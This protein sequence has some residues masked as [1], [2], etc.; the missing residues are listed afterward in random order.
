MKRIQPGFYDDDRGGLH[1]DLTEVLEASGY[2]NTPENRAVL[3]KAL[4]EVYPAGKI[5]ETD[6]P[7]KTDE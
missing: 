5:T 6:E 1:I 3:I 7:I 4:R 2:A